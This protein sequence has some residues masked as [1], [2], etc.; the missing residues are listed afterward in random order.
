[1]HGAFE[2]MTMRVV[3]CKRE[4]YDVY[5]GRPGPWGNPFSHIQGKGDV[6]VESR[7]EA[8][9]SYEKMLRSE[10]AGPHADLWKDS[11][12]KIAGKILGCWCSPK[13][14]HG[15]VLIKICSELGLI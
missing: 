11:L 15:D 3:H 2:T 10:L 8:I 14:C 1:M 9:S 12:T 7:D 6:L 4:S 5:I 13:S